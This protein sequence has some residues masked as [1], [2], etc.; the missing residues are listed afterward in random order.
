M[1]K[2][3]N[4]PRLPKKSDVSGS[5][6]IGETIKSKTPWVFGSLLRKPKINFPSIRIGRRAVAIPARSMMV[7]GIYVALFI[8]QMGVVYLIY[9]EPPALGADSSG[10]ALFIYP[11]IQESFII[12]SIVASILIFLFSLGYIFLYQASKYVYNRKIAIRILVIG[13]IFIIITFVS[14]QYMMAIKTQEIRD[15]LQRVI[16]LVS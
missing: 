1:A 5:R 10:N 11:D 12:E 9:R 3:D 13:F 7:L 14:L 6:T 8:L 16:D 15:F 4:S 2:K